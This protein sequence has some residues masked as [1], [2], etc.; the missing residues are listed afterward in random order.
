MQRAGQAGLADLLH[1]VALDMLLGLHSLCIREGPAIAEP[2]ASFG[3]QQ[4]GNG[5][6]VNGAVRS[7]GFH[8]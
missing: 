4:A 3:S 6:A 7:N 1:G 2:W 8:A 5:D